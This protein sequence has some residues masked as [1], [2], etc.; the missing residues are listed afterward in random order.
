MIIRCAGQTDV[1]LYACQAGQTDNGHVT[2]QHKQTNKDGECPGGYTVHPH[3]GNRAKPRG[4][5]NTTSKQDTT[6]THK[7]E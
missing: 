5:L 3:D 2:E 4:R 1:V 6:N 7:G